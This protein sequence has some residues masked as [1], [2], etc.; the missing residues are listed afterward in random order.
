M[1]RTPPP[2]RRI[3][4]AL[5]ALSTLTPVAFASSASAS[6]ESSRATGGTAFAGDGRRVSLSG[7]VEPTV[8]LSR[9]LKRLSAG[10]QLDITISLRVRDQSALSRLLSALYDPSSP[11]YWHFLTP[12]QFAQQFAPTAASRSQVVDWLKTQGLQVLGT[13]TNGLQIRAR[14]SV[15]KL[16][17]AFGTSLYEYKQDSHSFFANTSAISLPGTVASQVVAVSGLASSVQQHPAAVARAQARQTLPGYSPSD[18][19]SI[20][21][22]APLTSQGITGSGQTIAIA[23]FGDYAAS[24]VATY[25]QQYG[26]SGSMTRISVDGGALLGA[27]NGQDETEADIEIAQSTAQGANILV[28]EAPNSNT[29][30]QSAI[31]LYSRIVGD[32][33]ASIVTTSWGAAE[34]QMSSAD[35]AA[36]DQAFQ[37]GAAQGQAFFAASGDNGAYDNAGNGPGTDTELAVD[38]PASDPWVTGVGGTTLQANGSQ[39]VAESAWSNSSDSR[40]PAGSGGGLSSVFV[41]PS[42]Q[43]GPGVSNQYSNGKRQVPDVAADG[44]PNTG[45]A[46]YTVNSNDNPGW[47]VVGGTSPATPFWAGFAAIANQAVGGR[48]GFLNPT[49]Y[50]LGQKASSFSSS[51]FHDVTQ[52]SNLYYPATAGWDFATGWGSFDGAA[53]VAD[54]K[55][56]PA[57]TPTAT[58]RPTATPKPTAT[59]TRVASSPTISIKQVILLHRVK[60]KL[61]ATSSL[62][63]GETGTIVI[64]YQT[65]HAGSLKALGSVLVRENGQIVKATALK[66]TTYQGK[67]ALTAT[68]RF[69]SK[70]RVGTLVFHVTVK[71][72]S[73][74]AALDRSFR[75]W[76]K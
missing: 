43:T 64:L 8:R 54:L 60:G 67:P 48:I 68:I 65:K 61:Q 49:L 41:R 24:D 13:S 5:V 10:R 26:L 38:F 50:E 14:G 40:H 39:Y 28:Y 9:R 71:L 76:L 46:I 69:T 11:S 75:L 7:S 62:K 51:P 18:L 23:T 59:P 29:S 42:Y 45:Y 57:A 20:Y 15:S 17:A 27:K 44:D 72:G 58:P 52:G 36:L 34:E 19:A 33:Q 4:S 32:D 37:E 70:K 30:N 25:D 47:G 74:A 16:Q 1:S 53:F 21:D 31:D 66:A 56:L 3:L 2:R 55:T 6:T 73:V 63:V 22:L 35:I 12:R